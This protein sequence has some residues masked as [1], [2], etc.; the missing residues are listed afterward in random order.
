MEYGW[1]TISVLGY[2]V[3]KV[4]ESCSKKYNLL[5]LAYILLCDGFFRIIKTARYYQEPVGLSQ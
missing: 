3:S 4:S 1:E 5:W 2:R